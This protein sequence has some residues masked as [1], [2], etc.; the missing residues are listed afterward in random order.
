[1]GIKNEGGI[2]VECKEIS[3][4]ELN[5]FLFSR[6]KIQLVDVREIDEYRDG[7]LEGSQLI[8]LGTLPYRTYELDP[9]RP[10]VLICR[11]GNR[12]KEACQ[13][14]SDRGFQ[15]LSLR[16]GLTNWYAHTS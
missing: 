9:Y 1:V 2:F 13:M 7:H 5:Q 4:I 6:Q 3:T 14:L 12:S 16:G 15:A 11:S 8:P 10:V